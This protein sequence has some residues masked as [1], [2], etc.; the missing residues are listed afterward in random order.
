MN[1]QKRRWEWVEELI[2]KH[3]EREVAAVM[4][5][6]SLEDMEQWR[7]NRAYID[8]ADLVLLHNAFKKNQ[9]SE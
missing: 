5:F 6:P 7:R 4:G 2:A 9:S 8:I 3:G 1:D